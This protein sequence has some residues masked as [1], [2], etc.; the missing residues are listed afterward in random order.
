MAGMKVQ[1]YAASNGRVT[2]AQVEAF[3]GQMDG[4]E[5]GGTGRVHG[6]AGAME[7]QEV[8]NTVGNG[9]RHGLGG[10]GVVHHPGEYPGSMGAIQA[11]GCRRV[12][13]ILNAVV[14]GFDKQALLGVH[15]G[16][17]AWGDFKKQGIKFVH[18]PEKT[19]P[20]AHAL[21]LEVPPI[22]PVRRHLG[23]AV[24][25]RFQVFPKNIH[26]I[27]LGKPAAQ[28]D[29]GNIT[30]PNFGC[31][32]FI[33]NRWGNRFRLHGRIRGLPG[34]RHLRFGCTSKPAQPLDI[35]FHEMLHQG[36]NGLDFEKQGIAHIREMFAQ[37]IGE[38]NHQDG[39]NPIRFQG[40]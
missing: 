37:G 40:S 6:Q 16:G 39:I 21:V 25:A 4:G 24:F 29:D 15:L 20:F 14:D 13:R 33:D 18:I 32:D 38:L 26:I 22:P 35:G 23:D 28:T 11:E 12:P 3:Q 7:I 1:V 30:N 19:T 17:Q 8:G 10:V 27:C 2:G 36:I 9:K 5:R 31:R 34:L